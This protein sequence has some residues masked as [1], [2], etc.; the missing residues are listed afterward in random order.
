[1]NK[2]KVK[3]KDFTLFI[4]RERIEKRVA[5]LGAL[6]AKDYEGKNPLMIGVLNGAFMFMAA[7]VK[8]MNIPLEVS[9]LRLKSYQEMHSTGAVTELIGLEEGINGRNLLVIEDIIDTGL[10]M[11][12]LVDRLYDLQPAS[13]EVVTLLIK[14]DVQQQFRPKYVGFEIPDRFV[15]GYGLDYEGY[16]RNLEGIYQFSS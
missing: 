6:L 5:E 4:A 3:D 9:F 14:P 8:A 16:G 11:R 1:M 13:V 12:Y 7:L 10:T 2:I 15:V